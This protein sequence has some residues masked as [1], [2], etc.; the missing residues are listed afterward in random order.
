MDLGLLA[1]LRAMALSV[2]EQKNLSK[3][4][5]SVILNFIESAEI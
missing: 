5:G 1:L 3:S 4:L 2:L